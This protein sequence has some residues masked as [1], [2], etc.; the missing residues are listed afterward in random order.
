M[1]GGPLGTGAPGH[2]PSRPLSLPGFGCGPL[3]SPADVEA[4]VEPIVF[5][6]KASDSALAWGAA[7]SG[8]SQQQPHWRPGPR[9]HAPRQRLPSRA[10]SSPRPPDPEPGQRPPCSWPGLPRAPGSPGP[11]AAGSRR[12][13]VPLERGSRGPR[14]RRYRPDFLPRC[15]LTLS[16]CSFGS[17]WLPVQKMEIMSPNFLGLLK[18]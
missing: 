6:T 13:S 18:V 3:Q 14:M 11:P 7:G 9:P 2:Q 12:S 17:G 5:L 1:P 16:N 4:P 15:P 10:F 8:S